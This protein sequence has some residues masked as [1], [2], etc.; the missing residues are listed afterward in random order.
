MEQL[1]AFQ[2]AELLQLTVQSVGGAL[3]SRDAERLREATGSWRTREK[4]LAADFGPGM[5]D[6]VLDG[7]LAELLPCL[8]ELAAGWP[9]DS[10][11]VDEIG[12][13]LQPALVA[14][15]ETRAARCAELLPSV[16]ALACAGEGA[17]VWLLRLLLGHGTLEID[18]DL[19]AVCLDDA[20]HS[21]TPVNWLLA[22]RLSAMHRRSNPAAALTGRRLP[23]RKADRSSLEGSFWVAALS[24]LLECKASPD[25]LSG[26]GAPMFRVVLSACW[27][28]PSGGQEPRTTA[29]C[30]RLLLRH[31]A[32][33]D[34]PCFA[35]AELGSLSEAER[36]ACARLRAEEL[37]AVA[38]TWHV[39]LSW[40]SCWGPPTEHRLRVKSL[41]RELSAEVAAAAAVPLPPAS[42]GFPAH[43]RAL[44]RLLQWSSLYHVESPHS[45]AHA[46][47]LRDAVS[48]EYFQKRF[49]GSQAALDRLVEILVS[50]DARE[51]FDCDW[52]SYLQTMQLAGNFCRATM[53][54]LAL[55]RQRPPRLGS[56]DL[57]EVLSTLLR[58]GLG[59][60]HPTWGISRPRLTFD[61]GCR[62]WTRSLLDQGAEFPLAFA[63]RVVV[64]AASVPALWRPVPLDVA[65]RRYIAGRNLSAFIAVTPGGPAGSEWSQSSGEVTDEISIPLLGL[66]DAYCLD[67]LQVAGEA[68][69]FAVPKALLEIVLGFALSLV[70]FDE[71]LSLS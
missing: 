65:T 64:L 70:Y 53:L 71:T 59:Y 2:A 31:G 63:R 22:C 54:L 6:A 15:A 30:A 51:C 43:V 58:C 32:R 67:A 7:W 48:V 14:G 57:G 20:G 18:R 5:V 37:P 23:E 36:S 27:E 33:L 1:R 66:Y 60:Y 34:A 52:S 26:G 47:S 9:A 17:P 49:D 3:R 11:L 4:R 41:C 69:N 38:S 25:A 50:P 55:Q 39:L 10:R 56:S 19:A 68:T 46:C 12:E 13:Y 42:A 35:F 24:T 28:P 16:L 8:A 45:A 61:T 40:G 21:T 44:Y 29:N 62:A